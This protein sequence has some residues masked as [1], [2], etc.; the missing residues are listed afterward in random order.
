MVPVG[1][2]GQK[3]GAI[4]GAQDLLTA[5]GN[6]HD[7]SLQDA[8]ELFRLGMPMP[9]AGP[10]TRVQFKQVDADLLEPR[11]DRQP[12]SDLVPARLVEWL[13]ISGAGRNGRT[14]PGSG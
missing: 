1:I 6:E 4:S 10:R 7:L 9:L 12:M 11:G 8:D 5:F 3:A 13:W 14:G 2:P